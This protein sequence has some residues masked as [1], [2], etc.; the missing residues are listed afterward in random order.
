M[1]QYVPGLTVTHGFHVPKKMRQEIY[2]HLYYAKKYGPFQHM[3][4]WIQ[5]NEIKSKI[6]YGFKDWL[7][8][9]ISYIYIRLTI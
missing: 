6:I 1:K 9:S 7:I 4:R 3:N 5:D 8:G 2:R